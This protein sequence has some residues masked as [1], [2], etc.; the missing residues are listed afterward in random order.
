MTEFKAEDV[1]I[2]CGLTDWRYEY[3]YGV[4]GVDSGEPARKADG[5]TQEPL[6]LPRRSDALLASAVNLW[7]RGWGGLVPNFSSSLSEPSRSYSSTDILRNPAGT[8]DISA[9]LE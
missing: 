8:L 6:R 5:E 7:D 9:E 4:E 2:C 1:V 3:S